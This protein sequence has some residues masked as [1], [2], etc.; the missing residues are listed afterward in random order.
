MKKNWLH[1][2]FSEDDILTVQQEIAEVEKFTSGQIRLSIRD[3]RSLVEKLHKPH[4]LAVKDFERMGMSNTKH[5]T[6]ILI[7]IIFN[8]RFYDILADEG[9]HPK[10]PISTWNGLELKLKE[11]F[12]NGN[13]LN[14]ILHII[15]NVGDILKQEYPKEEGD[16]NELPDDVVVN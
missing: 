5:K 15:K 14:G 10:I 2:Y 8:E 6:G 1:K 16:S 12:R 7:F 4:E 3:K 11:E 13:Y 9:I